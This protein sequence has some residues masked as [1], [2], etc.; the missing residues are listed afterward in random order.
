[1]MVRVAALLFCGVYLVAGFDHDLG[2]PVAIGVLAIAA[3]F[4]MAAEER[5]VTP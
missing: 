3:A 4:M 5:E 1:M 2:F